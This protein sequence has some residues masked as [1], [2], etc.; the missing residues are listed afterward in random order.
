M[1]VLMRMMIM[2]KTMSAVMII[3]KEMTITRTNLFTPN[4]S[5]I[6]GIAGTSTATIQGGLLQL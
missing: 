4:M 5:S 6:G 1:M 3:G 2:G